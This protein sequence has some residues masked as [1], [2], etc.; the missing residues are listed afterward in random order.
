M[1]TSLPTQ[2]VTIG[3]VQFRLT[4]LGSK[5]GTRVLTRLLNLAGPS[6]EALAGQDERAVMS[7]LGSLFARLSPGD[8]EFFDS[9][10]GET[11]E[12]MRE[13]GYVRL[14]KLSPLDR[15]A[16]WAANFGDMF[17][18]LKSCID[19]NFASF[20]AGVGDIARPASPAKTS[21]QSP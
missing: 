5:K 13:H 4:A 12:I 11:T 20:L 19:L 21:A 17:S 8:L 14:A 9:E 15:D 10:F 3:G 7:A 2:E 6:V 16:L 18:W 1:P